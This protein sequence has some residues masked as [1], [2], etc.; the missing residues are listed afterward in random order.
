MDKFFFCRAFVRGAVF[1]RRVRAVGENAARAAF[2]SL[3]R[4]ARLAHLVEVQ[5]A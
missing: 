1:E 2:F 3:I 5:E 4:A